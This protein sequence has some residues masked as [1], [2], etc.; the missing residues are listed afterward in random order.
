MS[1]QRTAIFRFSPQGWFKEA[2]AASLV[3]M[4]AASYQRAAASRAAP[5]L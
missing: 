5:T 2:H 4:F 1:S 3:S